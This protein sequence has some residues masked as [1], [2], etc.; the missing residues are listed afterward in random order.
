MR[1][2]AEP[3]TRDE[4]AAALAEALDGWVVTDYGATDEI[5]DALDAIAEASPNPPAS[6][7]EAARAAYAAT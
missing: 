7:I 6:L 4:F 1:L 5:Q 3:M 2:T